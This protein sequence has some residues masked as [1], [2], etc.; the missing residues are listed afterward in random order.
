MKF[1]DEFV[2][3]AHNMRELYNIQ[4]EDP[5]VIDKIDYTKMPKLAMYRSP[6]YTML[7]NPEYTEDFAY[8]GANV[9]ERD[10]LIKDGDFNEANDHEQSDMV[11]VLLNLGSVPDSVAEKLDFAPDW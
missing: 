2:L 4:Y 10:K 1:A 11:M 8:I 6:W 7:S 3:E 9:E 5:R